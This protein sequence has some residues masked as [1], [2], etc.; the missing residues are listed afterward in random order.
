MRWMPLVILL[1]ACASPKLGETG[2]YLPFEVGRAWDYRI[3]EDGEPEFLLTTHAR[4]WDVRSLPDER[5]V[6]FQFVYGRPESVDQ[7]VTKSIYALASDGAREFHFSAWSWA[8]GHEP[9]I[10]LLPAKREGKREASWSGVV[11]YRGE[12]HETTATIRVEGIQ[13][14]ET[15]MGELNCI[16]VTTR[17]DAGKLVVRRWLAR[18]IGIVEIKIS[19]TAGDAVAS[20][21]SFRPPPGAD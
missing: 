11:E 1:T 17:Y 19:G 14:V 5:K 2:E 4:G 3:N 12:K 13:V 15:P 16:L 9:P 8:I 6:R 20:L 7:D 18:G 21:E 10:P